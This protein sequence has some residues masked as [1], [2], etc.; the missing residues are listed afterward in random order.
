MDD[1]RRC[2]MLVGKRLN[3]MTELTTDA[4]MADGGFKTLVSTGEPVL[5]DPK[6]KPAFMYT[7][8]T[9]SRHLAISAIRL[10]VVECGQAEKS[11]VP[12]TRANACFGRQ[13]CRSA[14]SRG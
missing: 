5:I 1:P 8:M 4:L 11:G 9:Q 2:Y 6:F 13:R 3:V 10:P 7:Q 14:A 12:G